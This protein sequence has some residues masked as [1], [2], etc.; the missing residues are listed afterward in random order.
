MPSRYFLQ[1]QVRYKLS[2][3]FPAVSDVVQEEDIIAAIGQKINQLLKLQ[4]LSE[5]LPSGDTIPQNLMIATYNDIPITTFNGKRCEATLPVQPVGL[6]RNMGVYL[7]D[8]YDDFRN[9]FIPLQSGQA[10]LLKG[11]PMINDLLNQVGY[12]PVGNKVRM[13]K[14]LTIDNVSVIHM[15]LLVMDI[16][17]YDD[18]TNLP[19]PADWGWQIIDEVYKSFIPVEA[20]NIQNEQ[21]TQQPRQVKK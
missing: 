11:Q 9:P 20:A 14:D 5:V 4:H 1:E 15:Q 18:Y 6:I 3:G 2:A 10:A 19:I 13:T 16:D 12:E 8:R 17:S 21:L 7:V